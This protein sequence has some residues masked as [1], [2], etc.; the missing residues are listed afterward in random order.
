MLLCSSSD[1]LPIQ[2][3]ECAALISCTLHFPPPLPSGT[4]HTLPRRAPNLQALNPQNNRRHCFTHILLD[5]RITLIV[6]CTMSAAA[7]LSQRFRTAPEQTSISLSPKTK[8]V[9]G[10]LF[11]HFIILSAAINH[12]CVSIV[13][14]YL[15]KQ[16]PEIGPYAFIA[17]LYVLFVQGST[18]VFT[19]LFSAWWHI[20]KLVAPNSAGGSLKG[21]ADRQ[22]ARRAAGKPPSRWIRVL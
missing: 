21:W 14:F 5:S 9:A 4:L 8:S 13:L 12:L 10:T 17:G 6:P 16:H 22:K 11:K 1:P 18:L 3:P 2:T 15:G 19:F 20:F 7:R